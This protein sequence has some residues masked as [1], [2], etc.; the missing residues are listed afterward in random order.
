M[1]ATLLYISRCTLPPTE[2]AEQIAE[3]VAAARSRN[4]ALNLTGALIWTGENFAQI[5]EGPADALDAVMADI[6][7]DARH[8]DITMLFT[9]P[10]QQRRFSDWRMA[11]CGS[12]SYVDRHLAQLFGAASAL[13]GHT[14]Q[15]VTLMEEYARM[16]QR[17][18]GPASEDR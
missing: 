15:L 14:E 2:G 12:A 13:N 17:R 6:R 11:Y 8:T 1:D 10:I 16:S 18:D 9:H 7:Q 5:L 4:A 3:L